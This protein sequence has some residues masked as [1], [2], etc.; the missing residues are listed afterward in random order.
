VAAGG[1]TIAF[2]ARLVG[3]AA[4]IARYAVLLAE[5]L[6]RLDGPERYLLLRGRKADPALGGR[7]CWTPPHH[8]LERFSLPLELLASRERPDV[9]HSLDHVAPAWGPWRSV[10]T[11]H[12]LAFLLYP[13]THTPESRTYYAA[14]GESARRA[15]RVIA[16]SQRTA[17]D[18]VRLLGVDPARMRVIHNAADPR[19][20]PRP[21][22]DLHELAARRGFDPRRPYALFV[23]TLEPRKNVPVLFEAMAAVRRHLDLD[24][25]LVGGRGWLDAPIQTA[26][27]RSGLGNAARFLGWLDQADLAVLYSHARVF[28][29]PSLYE[30]FG[31][32]VLEAMACGA[33]VVCSNAGPLPEVAG[34]AAILVPPNEP[35]AWADA[36]GRVVSDA[37][38]AA[39]LRARGEQRVR[40]FSWDRAAHATR[41][42]YREALLA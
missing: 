30:G 19:F 42:V 17:S 41:E 14:A 6:A 37:R 34:H 7:L 1:P 21:F 10:V 13:E 2:D 32:P 36:I 26:Y 25:V 40:A 27:A 35:R 12:D 31:L 11:L 39:D 16:V 5:A 9:L 38:L 8:R 24:L 4:G 20:G 22:E 33:P 15:A 18:A 3:Y 29:L 28:V 23:G